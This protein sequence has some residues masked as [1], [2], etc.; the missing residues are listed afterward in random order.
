M[1]TVLNRMSSNKDLQTGL[2][3]FR[4]QGI[5]HIPAAASN[6]ITRLQECCLGETSIIP[7]VPSS[8][9]KDENS[10]HRVNVG[11]HHNP[12][13][14]S[15]NRLH[16]HVSSVM[17]SSRLSSAIRARGMRLPSYNEQNNSLG[18]WIHAEAI[19]PTS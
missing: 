12:K 1:A 4:R 13:F 19:P 9:A 16:I 14:M 7:K 8:P 17:A 6:C 3:C 11:E 18:N 2:T 10:R 5:T 15:G